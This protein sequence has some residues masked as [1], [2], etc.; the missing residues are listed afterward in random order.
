M[1]NF[2]TENI[3]IKSWFVCVGGGL[4]IYLKN[5]LPFWW[6]CEW[7]EFYLQVWMIVGLEKMVVVVVDLRAFPLFGYFWFL[8][9]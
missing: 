9:K 5:V 4:F 6:L 2:W 8:E 1:D 7:K 3:F